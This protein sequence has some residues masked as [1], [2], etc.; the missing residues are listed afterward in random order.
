MYE[1][2]G[3]SN[4][5]V[6]SDSN[7]RSVHALRRVVDDVCA[8]VRVC[9]GV[10]LEPC[11]AGDAVQVRVLEHTRRRE[12]LTHHPV[13]RSRRDWLPA[14]RQPA[15]GFLP[16][17]HHVC[18]YEPSFRNGR[19]VLGPWNQ[20]A[21][22]TPSVE[23]ASFSLEEVASCLLEV[24]S[25]LLEA[26][27]LSQTPCAAD[28]CRGPPPPPLPPPGLLA[29]ERRSVSSVYALGSIGLQGCWCLNT[30]VRC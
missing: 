12:P 16:A 10:T 24:A 17:L 4:K 7:E 19:Q 23:R 11:N 1:C 21:I 29:A 6:A 3:S 8:R 18:S 25:C 15:F 22:D 13:L 5:N 9:V 27:C 14:C 28:K 30:A 26:S 20:H 2:S